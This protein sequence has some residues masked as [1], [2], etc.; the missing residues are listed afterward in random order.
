MNHPDLDLEKVR[1]QYDAAPYPKVPVEKSPKDE[2]TR[3]AMFLHCA[4]TPY[5]L[6]DQQVVDTHGM[7]ILDA[8]CGSG[9]KALLLAEANPGARIVG[10]D[11]S[12]ASVELARSRLKY[13]GFDNAEFHVGRIEDL[14]ALAQEFGYAFDYINCDEVLYMVP[15]PIACLAAMKAVLKPRGIIRGNFHSLYQRQNY[16]RALQLFKMMGLMDDNPEEFAMET[17]IELMN[18]LQDWVNLKALTWSAP[19]A[20]QTDL[21]KMAVGIR[22]NFL[23]QGD[24]GFTVTDVFN[25]LRQVDLKFVS[26]SYWRHWELADLFKNSEEL[27]LAIAMGLEAASQE[28]K[29]QIFELLHP[30]HRLIDFWCSQP[31]DPVALPAVSSEVFDW[32]CAVVHLHPV[33]LDDSV[34]QDALVCIKEQRAFEISRHINVPTRVS[35]KLDTRCIACLL[36]LWDAPQPF[37]ALVDRWLLLFPVDPITLAPETKERT[38]LKVRDLLQRLEVFLYVLVQVNP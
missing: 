12:Q 20:S 34:R 8:G 36:P 25:T 31:A 29:L 28:E 9:Y 19:F 18:G 32:N 1:Q 38:T 22:M 2:P 13:H 14:P 6:R 24:R 11:V 4:V 23:I 27:P 3:D 21:E 37:A 26:M 35:V 10:V 16:Y 30:M 17:V 33:L 15:D 7:T 5:Y